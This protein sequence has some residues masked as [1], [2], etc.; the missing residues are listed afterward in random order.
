MQHSPDPQG[1]LCGQ[2]GLRAVF[3][4]T[5]AAVS[6]W[7]GALLW[8]GS[9]LGGPA[10]VPTCSIHAAQQAVQSGPALTSQ[11]PPKRPLDVSTGPCSLEPGSHRR[12]GENRA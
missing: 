7:L 11:N 1:T 6:T 12:A 4:F 5:A 2:G 10:G 8:V 9:L 3:V